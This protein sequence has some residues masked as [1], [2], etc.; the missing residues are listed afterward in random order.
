[1]RTFIRLFVFNPCF[2]FGLFFILFSLFAGFFVLTGAMAADGA[3][4]EKLVMAALIVMAAGVTAG[5]IISVVAARNVLRGY[6]GA[7][8][9]LPYFGVDYFTN[10]LISRDTWHCPSIGIE[11]AIEEHDESKR[12]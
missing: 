3:L 2:L 11:L 10:C 1:M 6:R 4:R 8:R 5:I 12:R 7:T 9:H